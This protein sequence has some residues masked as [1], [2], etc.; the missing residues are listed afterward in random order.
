MLGLAGLMSRDG[1]D[2]GEWK[3][4]R[5]SSRGL[6]IRRYCYSGGKKKAQ[7]YPA[8][9][10]RHLSEQEIQSLV[11]RENASYEQ[12]KRKAEAEYDFDHAYASQGLLEKYELELSKSASTNQMVKKNRAHLDKALRFFIH[13]KELPSPVDWRK[14]EAE[15]G[16]YIEKLGGGFD[17][18]QRVIQATNRYL[19]F[20]H[21]QFPD[22]I[23]PIKLTPIAP[24]KLKAKAILDRQRLQDGHRFVP[25]EQWAFI[26]KHI[27]RDLHSMVQF[28]Y[29]FGLRRS[30]ALGL[31]KNSLR[32]GYL[33]IERQLESVG[34]DASKPQYT[35]LKDVTPRKVPYWYGKPTEV[36]NWFESLVLMHPDSAGHKLS[37]E[38]KR[39]T[40]LARQMGLGFQLNF[41]FHDF[42]RTFITRAAQE[43]GAR[44]AMLAAGH[45]DLRTTSGYLQDTRDLD[46]DL[47]L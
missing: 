40:E 9:R 16:K 14:H 13:I 25:E 43:F 23:P 37:Q 44:E 17:T 15:F 22:E 36:I 10:Y 31:T 34:E 3:I 8:S 28:C 30:E 19:S 11:I 26:Q 38:M 32:K 20:L 42:R 4:E 6:Y 41:K 7:N 1:V 33:Y 46:D 21:Y 47:L 5:D 35:P 2:W 18:Q 29:K 27:S 12:K 45:D 24:K 39:M